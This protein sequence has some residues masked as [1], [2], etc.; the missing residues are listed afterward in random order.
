MKQTASGKSEKK[1]NPQ[2]EPSEVYAQILCIVLVM[3]SPKKANR[4]GSE[5]E[6]RAKSAVGE[7]GSGAGREGTAGGGYKNKGTLQSGKI[8]IGL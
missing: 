7:A 6:R 2:D 3:A 4:T 8:K 5:A 1:L